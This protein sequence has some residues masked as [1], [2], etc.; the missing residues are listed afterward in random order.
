MSDKSKLTD[1]G[2]NYM[3]AQLFIKNLGPIS[4]C[5]LTL[6]DF[7]VLTGKQASGKSTIAKC[8]YFFRTVKDDIFVE[9]M[10]YKNISAINQKT[11]LL[12]TVKGVIWSK[13]LQLFNTLLNSDGHIEYKYTEKT[14]VK[15]SII[16]TKSK[17]GHCIDVEFSDNITEF[18]SQVNSLPSERNA[19]QKRLNDLF[20][21]EYKTIFIPAGRSMIS[22]FTIQ[23]GYIF[24]T[25]NDEQKR[26]LDYCTQKFIEYILM[27]RPLFN[28][29]I[30]GLAAVRNFD[31][32]IAY[33][34]RK[35]IENVLGGEYIY[36]NGDELLYFTNE[37]GDR[38]FV[39]MN[40][41]SSGQQESVWIF[42]ILFSLITAKTKAF[43]IVEE[44]EAHLYPD[45]QKQISELLAL[46][47]NS[48]CQMLITTHSPYILGA[49]NNLMYASYISANNTPKADSLVSKNKQIKN[50]CAYYVDNGKIT[51]CLEDSPEKLIKNEV[52]DGVSQEI[53]RLY[54]D[55][56]EASLKNSGR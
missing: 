9:I 47:L 44:P 55:L 34:A 42:N 32:K 56:F 21:D 2:S 46:T 31:D 49:L 3:K 29:G 48:G 30:Q 37:Q 36:E 52:I 25:M 26:S 51:S 4:E 7:T 14:W 5:E 10:K 45:A 39:R 11:D 41:A 27:I 24:A 38:Q 35:I 15:I 20:C 54:D 50:Y 40:Y 13:F 22:L 16:Q 17:S 19:L 8:I 53:N 33:E 18:I 12:N 28:N 23:L 1:V 6:N 43:V